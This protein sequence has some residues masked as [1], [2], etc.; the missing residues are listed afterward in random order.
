MQSRCGILTPASS[1]AAEI[2]QGGVCV[3]VCF[4]KI[5]NASFTCCIDLFW[6]SKTL[7]VSNTTRK[8]VNKS[9]QVSWI[10]RQDLTKHPGVTIES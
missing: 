9:S 6:L 5:V 3:C 4:G 8:A 1:S 2:C 10:L 7:S